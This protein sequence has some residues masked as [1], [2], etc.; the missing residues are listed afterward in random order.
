VTSAAALAPS[1]V[2]G[3]IPHGLRDPLIAAYNEI[4]RNFRESRWEP[5]ELNGGKLCEVTYT[6]LKGL[7]DGTYPAAPS[8]PAN[9]VDA[10]KGLESAD[11]KFPRSVR[12]QIPRVLIALYE[13]RNNRGVG[14]VGGEVDPNH[15]DA[16]VVLSMAKWTIA[17]LIRIYHNT[18]VTTATQVVDALT[19]RE[20][21][22][23][24]DVGG[25]RRILNVSLKMR[26]KML[27]LLYASATPVAE[28]DLVSWL[29]Y[30]N[31]RVFR[32]DVLDK[33]HADRLIEYNRE[34]LTVQ[35]SPLGA[36]YVEQNLPLAI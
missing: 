8:K 36:R 26:E 4:V 6:I 3:A 20:I 1:S 23:V 2:L 18:D 19:E 30:S 7:V 35:I 25:K 21:P 11:K 15:M 12:I 29:E 16:V 13:I 34:R 10:C 33:A 22:I 5:S 32:K 24:W 17:E 27:I 9:M 31:P 14:H 28:A